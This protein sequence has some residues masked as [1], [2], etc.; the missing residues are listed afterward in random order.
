MIKL[1]YVWGENDEYSLYR[2]VTVKPLNCMADEAHFFIGDYITN[3]ETGL[4]VEL[5]TDISTVAASGLSPSAKYNS[6]SE[7]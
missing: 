1:N 2:Y 5:S 7:I 4:Q 6:I 3:E